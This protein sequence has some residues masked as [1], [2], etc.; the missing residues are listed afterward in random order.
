MLWRWNLPRLRIFMRPF[1]GPISSNF[2]E[3][4]KNHNICDT[5][6]RTASLVKI[7]YKSDVTWGFN[8]GKTTQKQPNVLLFATT[9]NFEN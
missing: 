2:H 6:P 5:L 7:L 3:Y 9:K 4:I 1:F 8:L